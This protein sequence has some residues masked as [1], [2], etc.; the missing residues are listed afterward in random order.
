MVRILA[1]SYQVTEGMLRA[2]YEHDRDRPFF[3][4]RRAQ[5]SSVAPPARLMPSSA[6]EAQPQFGRPTQPTVRIVYRTASR[7][8]PVPVL[9]ACKGV[10]QRAF[11]YPSAPEGPKAACRSALLTDASATG[12]DLETWNHFRSKP[13]SPAPA[14][15]PA[16]SRRE[17]LKDEGCTLW[18]HTSGHAFRS[19]EVIRRNSEVSC[20]A[21]DTTFALRFPR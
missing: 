2:F 10:T 17:F 14:C 7:V 6:M 5:L 18:R 13:P 21:A 12:A 20:A 8:P 1:R 9:K 4:P 11:V 3:P 19:R 16:S 15:P